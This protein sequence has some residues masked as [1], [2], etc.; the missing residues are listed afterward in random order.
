MKAIM[1]VKDVSLNY[2]KRLILENVSCQLF[3]GEVVG[4][5]GPNGAGKTSLMK[6]LLDFTKISSGKLEK[7]AI[8][9]AGLIEQPGLYPFMTGYEHLEFFSKDSCPSI[10]IHQLIHQFDLSKFI[11]KKTQDYSL[12]MKQR[13]GIALALLNAPDIIILDEPMNG[14]D[15]YSVKLL[16]KVILTAR[17]EGTTFLISSHIL[18]E[19]EQIVDRVLLMKDGR[20]IGNVEHPEYLQDFEAELIA[21]LA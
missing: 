6:V 14:L 1:E 4:L 12:G 13:L 3:T 2:K 20:I 10:R 21:K 11:Y 19:L 15:P 5:V 18:S 9:L 8:Q 16:K 7:S 17:D